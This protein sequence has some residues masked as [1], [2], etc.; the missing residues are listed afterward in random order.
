MNLLIT[1]SRNKTIIKKC[2]SCGH[3]MESRTEVQK[4][5]QCN[6]PFLPVNYHSKET[7][8]TSLDFYDQFQEAEELSEE[9][10]VRGI[11]VLW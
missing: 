10:L 8:K 5:A 9:T 7:A 11:Q 6:K 1:T 4:C 3:I 2:H